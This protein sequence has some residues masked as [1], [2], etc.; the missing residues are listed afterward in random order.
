M[1]DVRIRDPDKQKRHKYPYYR[2][3]TYAEPYLCTDSSYDRHNF[4]SLELVI[5]HDWRSEVREFGRLK[6]ALG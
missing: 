3:R 5:E 4:G 1:R 6:D 2:K